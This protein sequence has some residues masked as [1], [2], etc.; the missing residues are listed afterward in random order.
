MPRQTSAAPAST[1]GTTAV[2]DATQRFRKAIHSSTSRIWIALTS[3]GAHLRERLGVGRPLDDGDL[4]L[5]RADGT[6]LPVREYS[7][8]FGAQQT[9]AGLKPIPLSK[10]RHSNISRMRAAGIAADV[11]AAWHGHTERMTQAV[12][13]RVTDDRLTAAS[14]VFSTAIGQS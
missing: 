9:A 12:Y 10:L 6:W 5:S 7:R 13:G 2:I 1:A 14:A 11:V 4:L 3:F 8:E